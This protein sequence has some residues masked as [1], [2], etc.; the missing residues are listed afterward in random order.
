MHNELLKRINPV[1]GIIWRGV[2]EAGHVEVNRRLYN[3]ELVFFSRGRGRVII[4]GDVYLCDPGSLVI[5][6]PGAVHCTIADS[7]I[8]RWCIHFDWE[9]G[10]ELPDPPFEY[11][12]AD[13]V[14]SP[15]ACNLTPEWVKYPLPWQKTVEDYGD[16][17]DLIKAVFKMASGTVEDDIRRK[18]AMLQILAQCF[19]DSTRPETMM[20]PVLLKAKE[21]I[22][23]HFRE[24]KLNVSIAARHSGVTANHL[25]RLFRKDLNMSPMDYINSLRL[26]NAAILLETSPLNV[27][28]AAASSGIQDSNYFARMFRKKFG[29][30]PSKY[31]ASAKSQRL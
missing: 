24:C 10:Q 3:H 1:I 31:P 18:G 2:F 5:I 28:Q 19:D 7:L 29:V 20:S 30:S 26:K 12:D 9:P 25:C 4:D 27:A 6:P 8:E 21:Y 16:F 13:N 17:L 15:S 11:S 23:Q 22:D 14:F